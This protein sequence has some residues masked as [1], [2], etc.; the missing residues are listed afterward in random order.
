MKT[1]VTVL[2]SMALALMAACGTSGGSGDSS[3]GASKSPAG[4]NYGCEGLTG[5]ALERCKVRRDQGSKS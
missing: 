5:E 3:G 4:T 1:L 2:A